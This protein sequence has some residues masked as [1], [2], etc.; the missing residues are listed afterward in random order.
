[1]GARFPAAG[2]TRQPASVRRSEQFPPTE[3][4]RLAHDLIGRLGAV[5]PDDPGRAELRRQAIEA[6]LPMAQRLARRY[7]GRGENLDDLQQTA[8]IGLIKAVD[9]FD[10]GRGVDF[11][12]FAFPTIL[13]EIKRYLRDRAWSVRV[14]RKVQEMWLAINRANMELSQMLSRLPTV[15]DIARHL[16]V[17]EEEVLEGLEGG[18]AYRATSL[19]TPIAGETTIELGDMLGEEDREYELVEMRL[20]LGAAVARLDAREQRILAMRFWG[21]QTQAGI[22]EQIGVS[23][24]HVSRIL[25]AALAKLRTEIDPKRVGASMPTVRNGA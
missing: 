16:G 1:M 4:D 5:A 21:N 2:D 14:P 22:A 20:T 9:R 24:M 10:P 25:S 3:A 13:G 7:A 15:T 17:S 19:S 6:W 11:V 8:T 23:Q 12:G 18:N